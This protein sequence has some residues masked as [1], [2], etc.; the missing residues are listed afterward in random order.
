MSGTIKL[1]LYDNRDA[2]GRMGLPGMTHESA[3]RQRA[4]RQTEQLTGQR[5]EPACG[6]STST[7]GTARESIAMS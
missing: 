5:A 3:F 4:G 7:P 6:C 2:A 1:V